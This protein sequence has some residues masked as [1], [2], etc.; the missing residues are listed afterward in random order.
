[1]EDWGRVVEEMIFCFLFFIKVVVK[2]E[3]SNNLTL[4][5][6]IYLLINCL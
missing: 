2:I 1:M 3:N 4:K 5:Y 6:K